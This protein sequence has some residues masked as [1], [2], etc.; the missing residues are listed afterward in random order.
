[1][2]F[3]HNLSN[4]AHHISIQPRPGDKQPLSVAADGEYD[5]EVDLHGLDVKGYGYRWLRLN[6]VP[7]V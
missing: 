3:V 2:L 5:D 6:H 1:M 4:R 7:W